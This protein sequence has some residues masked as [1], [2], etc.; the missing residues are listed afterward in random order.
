MKATIVVS[1]SGG[2]DSVAML[3]KLVAKYGADR[4]LTHHQVLPEDWPETIDYNRM[5]CA[6]LGVRLVM[7]QAVYGP[8]PGPKGTE[9]TMLEVR[10]IRSNADIVMPGTDG[11]IAG[12]SD[13]ALRRRWPPSPASR[14]CTSYFKVEVLDKWLRREFAGQEVEVIVCLGE[15]ALESSR[16]AKKPELWPRFKS[17]IQVWNW[18]PVHHL[19]RRSAFRTIRDF[20]LDIHPAYEAQGMSNQQMLDEDAEGGPRCSCRFCIY[21]AWPEICH[22]AEMESNRR[23]LDRLIRVERQTGRSWWHSR[24]IQSLLTENNN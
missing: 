20:G 15:R 11:L 21:A 5:V 13:L 18:L 17:R 22:Q 9:T 12:V 16:R 1:L 4:L 2:K 7:E 3:A 14:W 8:R 10:E 24:S 23:L 6:T 19:T